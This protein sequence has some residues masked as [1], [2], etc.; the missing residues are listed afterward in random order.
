M[1]L[2]IY[3]TNNISVLT[4]CKIYK[5]MNYSI[6]IILQHEKALPRHQLLI[7]VTATWR[8]GLMCYSFSIVQWYLCITLQFPK[9]WTMYSLSSCNFNLLKVVFILG[10]QYHKTPSSSRITYSNI[11]ENNYFCVEKHSLL[12]NRCILYTKPI[13]A[14]QLTLIWWPATGHVLHQAQ[15]KPLVTKRF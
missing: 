4:I 5:S 11:S 2:H 7:L 10:L 6:K 15:L 1:C 14:K 9:P 3:A 8:T 12:S 13:A